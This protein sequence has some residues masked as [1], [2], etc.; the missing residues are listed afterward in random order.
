M[1][2]DNNQNLNTNTNV[3]NMNQPAQ[4]T[5]NPTVVPETP[6]QNIPEPVVNQV[7][8]QPVNIQPEVV[9]PTP[10]V[11]EPTVTPVEVPAESTQQPVEEPVQQ[12]IKEEP[13]PVM[14]AL[15]L[16]IKKKDTIKAIIPVENVEVEEEKE[17]YKKSSLRD[18]V[19]KEVDPKVRKRNNIL[20]TLLF[21]FLF[22]F[23][24]VIP[25][26]N[27]YLEGLNKKDELSE[28]EKRAREIE[29]EQN[30]KQEEEKKE[31]EKQ[32]QEEASLKKMTC[33][34][35]VPASETATYSKTTVQTFEYNTS[36]QVVTSGIKNTY[37]FT[38]PDANYTA[39]TQKCDADS[40]KYLDKEGYTMSCNYTELE[41]SIG[42]EFD[43]EK[44][45]PINDG[46][47]IITSNATL[48]EDVNALKQRLITSGYTCE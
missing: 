5:I 7:P 16:S 17:T 18:Y 33:T 10:S 38:T 36:N 2:N 44:F 13:K 45:S 41:V 11:I 12:E 30:K 27:D 22:V 28:I 19:P 47:T 43:L 14:S 1:N 15:D 31:K 34:L 20:I 6:V 21:I 26:I 46:A 3:E 42:N 29:Q 9:Q 39:L 4:P 25:Y 40:L 37:T 48:N 8:V 24:M 32:I 35:V 23:V